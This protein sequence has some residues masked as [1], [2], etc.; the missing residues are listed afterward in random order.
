MGVSNCKIISLTAQFFLFLPASRG[1]NNR[2]NGFA[3]SFF[4]TLNII[5]RTCSSNFLHPLFFV[6]SY[7]HCSN[8]RFCWCRIKPRIRPAPEIRRWASVSVLHCRYSWTSQAR[9]GWWFWWL[10]RNWNLK[11]DSSRTC[12]TSLTLVWTTWSSG[13]R[14][15]R[16]VLKN[17]SIQITYFRCFLTVLISHIIKM[18]IEAIKINSL[19]VFFSS[20][21][22]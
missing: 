9:L 2:S 22:R 21:N 8:R 4:H 18:V 1:W 20:Q 5:W 3:M 7:R 11:T 13:F 19:C 6:F 15:F 17:M 14:N 16:Y 12:S 10:R